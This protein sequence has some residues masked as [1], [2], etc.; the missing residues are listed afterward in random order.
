MMVIWDK[1]SKRCERLLDDGVGVV[2][3]VMKRPRKV[4]GE[5][6]GIGDDVGGRS[7]VKS[8]RDRMRVRDRVGKRVG[9][10]GG[11]NY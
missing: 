6:V 1:V 4:C 3:G 9:L 11:R 2:D 10:V 7:I 5:D 8:L